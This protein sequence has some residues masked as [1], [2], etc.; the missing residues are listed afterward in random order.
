MSQDNTLASSA[1]QTAQTGTSEAVT[2]TTGKP[3]TETTEAKAEETTA[4]DAE[5]SKKDDADQPSDEP[6]PKRKGA[7]ERIAELTAKAHAAKRIAADKDRVIQRL[8]ERVKTLEAGPPRENDYKSFEEFEAAKA[9]YHVK[10]ATKEDREADIKIASDEAKSAQSDAQAALEEIFHERAQDFA[11]R[12][13]DYFQKVSDNSLPITVGMRDEIH[14]SEKGPEIAYFLAN[15]RAEA[16][17]IARLTDSRE[18]ARAI[19]RIEGRLGTPPPKKVTTAP[20]PVKAVATGSG[21]KRGFDPRTASV[22]DVRAELKRAGV[23][24]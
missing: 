12:V 15:N 13:P 7:Q 14:A 11:D 18:I 23:I 4:A 17:R 8:E 21:S 1:E 16:A 9:T 22:D 24:E 10:Q 3:V 20:A 19:G 6:K 5:T 2:E